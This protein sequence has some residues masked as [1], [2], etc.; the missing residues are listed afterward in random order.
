MS[1]WRMSASGPPVYPG[2]IFLHSL[3]NDAPYLNRIK[4]EGKYQL[5][6]NRFGC[7]GDLTDR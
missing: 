2:Q 6:D 7:R 1:E 4:M 3:E 5:C